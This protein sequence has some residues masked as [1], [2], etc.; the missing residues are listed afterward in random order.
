M[1]P[2]MI[3]LVNGICGFAAIV[4]AAKGPEHFNMA[5]YLIFYAMI[6]DVLGKIVHRVARSMMRW[7]S[8]IRTWASS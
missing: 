8:C 3:T 5:A 6:A 4:L 2:S 1:L 7:I